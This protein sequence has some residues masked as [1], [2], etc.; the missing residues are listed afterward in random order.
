MK[1]ILLVLFAMVLLSGCASQSEKFDAM[2]DESMIAALSDNGLNTHYYL[3]DPAAFGLKSVPKTLGRIDL[4][5]IN[6]KKEYYDSVKE[7]NGYNYNELSPDQQLTYDVLKANLSTVEKSLGFGL[8]EELLYPRTGV[9]SNLPVLFAEYRI[10]NEKDIK[11]Y[12]SLLADV[13]KYFRS[14]IAYEREH[15]RHGFFMPEKMVYETIAVCEAFLEKPEE[16]FLITSFKERVDAL[17]LPADKAAKY[18]AKN[19]KLVRGEVLPAYEELIAQLQDWNGYGVNDGGLTNILYG[20]QYYEY[21]IAAKSGSS[22]SVNEI[23]AILDKYIIDSKNEMLA[24]LAKDPTLT[25]TALDFAA[26]TPDE[27][28]ARLKEYMAADYPEMPA[29]GEEIKYLPKSL[30]SM[31]T[32]G[33]YLTPPLDD[34]NRNIIYINENQ[35][36]VESFALL[37]HEGYP[38]HLY[39]TVYYDSVNEAPLRKIMSFLAYS[40][41][42]ATYVEQE[43]YAWAGNNSPDLVR[44]T[45]LAKTRSMSM[46]ARMEI[47]I[48]YDGWD[49]GE[50]AQ[51]Y[52]GFGVT[53]SLSVEAMYEYCLTDPVGHI[54]YIIGYFEIMQ[55]RDDMELKQGASFNLKDFHTALLD[56]G[57]APFSVVRKHLGL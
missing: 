30:A 24:L 42:W 27:C 6:D 39:Q 37:A 12:F 1:K 52:A 3:K 34:P 14:V 2:L 4:N 44:F 36:S 56:I 20:D 31:A 29:V 50:F 13:D 28:I 57:P 23:S 48:H 55:L 33:F 51:Y 21:L 25:T 17:N 22:K 54:P 5:T 49:R 10:E 53:D 18:I 7:L 45:Q 43:S 11:S 19:E 38:G 9:Q 41:G 46:M 47:G 16:N 40:E 15:A 35:P 32:G 8:Y 26:K